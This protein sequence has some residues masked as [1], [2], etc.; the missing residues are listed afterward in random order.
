MR[1]AGTVV[2]LPL[3]LQGERV[4][5]RGSIRESCACG[6]TPHPDPL[7][8][9]SGERERRHS[10]GAQTPCSPHRRSPPCLRICTLVA[11]IVLGITPACAQSAAD[12]G[13][14]VYT[15]HCATCHG[16]R[17]SAT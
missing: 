11:T 13:R 9:K 10:A 17:L 6:S 16:E 3:P 15:E 12:A 4:G 1:E 8:A 5:V 7:P 14:D 2:A